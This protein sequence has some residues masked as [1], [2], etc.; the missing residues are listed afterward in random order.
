M[1]ARLAEG[2]AIVT[3]LAAPF[4]MSLAAVSKHLRVLG[5]TRLVEQTVEGR[6]HRYSLAPKP[7]QKVDRW[8]T[9]YRSFWENTLDSLARYVEQND[10]D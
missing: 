10:N 5:R 2:P 1:L 6:I 8:L 4:D 7:L 9:H 3:E